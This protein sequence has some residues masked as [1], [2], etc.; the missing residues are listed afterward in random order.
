MEELDIHKQIAESADK[1]YLEQLDKFVGMDISNKK[2]DI[3][4]NVHLKIHGF[5][6]KEY[7]E[8]KAKEIEY[9]QD[10]KRR[11]KERLAEL[12]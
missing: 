2:N 6:E 11:I 4:K 12:A 1:E 7:E 10:L 9:F 8:R 3:N 5:S